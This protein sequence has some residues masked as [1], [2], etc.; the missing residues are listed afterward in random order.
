MMRHE[1]GSILIFIR[2][3]YARAVTKVRPRIEL[4]ACIEASL[5]HLLSL[6]VRDIRNEVKRDHI[7]I[8]TCGDIGPDCDTTTISVLIRDD[9]IERLRETVNTNQIDDAINAALGLW[10][11]S[12]DVEVEN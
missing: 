1:N 10:L 8:S 5:E 9:L 6:P 12:R 7:R 2:K 4:N 3:D 11:R